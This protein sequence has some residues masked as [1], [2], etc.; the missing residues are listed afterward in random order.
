MFGLL[1]PFMK[2][3]NDQITAYAAAQSDIVR[4]AWGAWF[5]PLQLLKPVKIRA[6]RS[7]L[8]RRRPEQH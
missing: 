4:R 7:T 5:D 8:A 1:D 6:G 2:R 3:I